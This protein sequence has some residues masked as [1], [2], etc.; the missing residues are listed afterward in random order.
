MRTLSAAFKSLD[1]ASTRKVV[2]VAHIYY[3]STHLWWTDADKD[4]T[5]LSENVTKQ[6]ISISPVRFGSDNTDD[7]LTLSAS[8]KNSTFAQ[9]VLFNPSLPVWGEFYIAQNDNLAEYSKYFVGRATQPSFN[10]QVVALPFV[11]ISHRLNN[12]VLRWK[13]Q[14]SCNNT[15][16]DQH[17]GISKT[18]FERVATV[19]GINTTNGQITAS[20]F[21]LKKDG[22]AAPDGWYE[23]GFVKFDDQY[24]HIVTHVG[25][26]LT[27]DN[28]FVG[29]TVTQQ[30]YAYPGCNLSF[31]GDCS[32]SKFNNQANFNGFPL[33]PTKNPLTDGFK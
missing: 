7:I 13:I 29:L 12:P 14:A 18:D 10:K 11:S 22:S 27:L 28:N 6:N 33:V 23:L 32:S 26:T 17:C 3:G 25:T 9:Y 16:Y 31:S 19:T 2:K 21:A 15:L 24:R 4:F 30:V 1:Q 5:F 20:E 8:S